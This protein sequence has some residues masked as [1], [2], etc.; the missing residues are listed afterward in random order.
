MLLPAH[1]RP[2]LA[3]FKRRAPQTQAI[4]LLPYIVSRRDPISERSHIR[5]IP[6]RR[7]PISERSYIGEL[8]NQQRKGLKMAMQGDLQIDND[9]LKR[10]REE[11][12]PPSFA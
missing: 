8:S 3:E 4:S 7:D 6:S 2:L 12:E 11:P 9:A 5:E 10:K 1:A